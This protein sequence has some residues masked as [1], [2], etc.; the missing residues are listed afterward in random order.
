MQYRVI[1]DIATVGYKNWD[2]PAYGLLFVAI[3]GVIFIYR[4]QFPS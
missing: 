4:K 1:F 3:S 2:F